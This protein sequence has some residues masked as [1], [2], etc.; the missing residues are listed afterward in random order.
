MY[1]M[2]EGASEIE[3]GPDLETGMGRHGHRYPHARSM[4]CSVIAAVPFIDSGDTMELDMG[5]DFDDDSA[6]GMS[7][8]GDLGKVTQAQINAAADRL[9][10]LQ[11]QATAA[12]TNTPKGKA[13]LKAAAVVSKKLATISNTQTKQA[14]NAAAALVAAQQKKAALDKKRADDL[15]ALQKREREK[16][17]AVLLREQTA[18]QNKATRATNIQARKDT[19]ATNKQNRLD[20]IQARKDAR[21]AGKPPAV[22]FNPN[23]VPPSGPDLNI[24]DGGMFMD[25]PSGVYASTNLPPTGTMFDTYPVNDPGSLQNQA[26]KCVKARNAYNKAYTNLA[27]KNPKAWARRS[28]GLLAKMNAACA[29]VTPITSPASQYPP[30]YNTQLPG[31]LRSGPV[32]GTTYDVRGAICDQTAVPPNAPQMCAQNGGVWDAFGQIC[33]GATFNNPGGMFNQTPQGPVGTTYAG[34]DNFGQ[35]VYRDQLGRYVNQYGQQVSPPTSQ[36]GNQFQMGPA[37][38]GA[39]SFPG[40]GGGFDSGI[41]SNDMSIDTD[42]GAGMPTASATGLPTT[43]GMPMDT[44]DI[45]ID[46]TGADSN[47][48]STPP[49]PESLDYG[50]MTME[51]SNAV[52]DYSAPTN[53]YDSA[54]ASPVSA[55]EVETV[56]DDSMAGSG[57]PPL[58]APSSTVRATP[59]AGSVTPW[60][61]SASPFSSAPP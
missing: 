25:D 15:A 51:V 32:Q 17:A 46:E 38:G 9:A 35:P 57:S 49:P 61:G 22:P 56:E 43:G 21:I 10:K 40:G 37:A 13:L 27:A 39:M 6:P 2:Q 12:G 8:L 44:N 4:N 42:F 60:M 7:G 55:D 24:D 19:A 1:Y 52:P 11:S 28:V 26:P 54:P 18:A 31:V 3:A 50:G 36:A 41:D 58:I 23:A 16:Q 45:Y 29:A 20:T 53:G 5:D 48:A 47:A 59:S 33:N 14:D 30:C 34:T